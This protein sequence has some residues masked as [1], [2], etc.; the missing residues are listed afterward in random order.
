MSGAPEVPPRVHTASTH[1]KVG[2]IG[3]CCGTRLGLDLLLNSRTRVG[4]A[5]TGHCLLRAWLAGQEKLDLP[6]CPDS[7]TDGG[8]GADGKPAAR[9]RACRSD[10]NHD[11]GW[12][13]G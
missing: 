10:Q 7:V 12:Q 9:A 5:A 4:A 1:R 8:P 11:R 13:S 2:C 6:A 3:R